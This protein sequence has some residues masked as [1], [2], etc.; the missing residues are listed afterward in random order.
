[1]ERKGPRSPQREAGFSVPRPKAR[2][3]EEFLPP[4]EGQGHAVSRD[5]PQFPGLQN[6]LIQT[7]PNSFLRCCKGLLRQ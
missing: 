4:K 3:I 5:L 1:M 2:G 6:G 7:Y